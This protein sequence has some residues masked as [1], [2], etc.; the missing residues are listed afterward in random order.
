VSQTATVVDPS[1]L[2]QRLADVEVIDVRT[3]GEFEAIHLPRARNHPLERL[4][5]HL[6]EIR[7][8][9]EGDRDV[10]LICRTG[11]RAHRAQRR[12]AEAGVGD[13][14]VVDGGVL[15]WE[16]D[17]GDVVRDVIRWDLERQVRLVAGSLV[18]GSVATS[19]AW[20][21]ARYLAG[22]I[23][24]GLVFAAVTGTCGMARVLAKLPYNRPRV[25]SAPPEATASQG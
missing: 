13:I 17:G 22:A 21:P 4:D 9:V 7:E 3:P 20:P 6:D 25:P 12:L 1:T 10:V 5:D 14:P 24:A 11:M 15:A 8:L 19:V 18:L 2:Q 16:A 23:G